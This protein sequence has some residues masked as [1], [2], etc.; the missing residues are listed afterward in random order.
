M[1]SQEKY[2]ESPPPEWDLGDWESA[3]TIKVGTAYACR[4]CGNLIMV[5]R[6]GVGIL[7]LV[8]CGEPMERVHGAEAEPE[9]EE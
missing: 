5:T 9:E 7:D 6:G 2:P 3:L 1:E 8:C 4:G